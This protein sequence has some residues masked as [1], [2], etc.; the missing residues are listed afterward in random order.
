[1]SKRVLK[2]PSPLRVRYEALIDERVE[3]FRQSARLELEI[4]RLKAKQAAID[5]RIEETKA[6]TRELHK[7]A[8]E[9]GEVL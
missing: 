9:R 4:K 2:F 8:D 7:L 5:T 1:M 3:L 6:E